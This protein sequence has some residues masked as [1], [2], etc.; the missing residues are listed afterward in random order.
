MWRRVHTLIKASSGGTCLNTTSLR[1]RSSPMVRMETLIG[2]AETRTIGRDSQ[3]SLETSNSVHSRH[4]Y[5]RPSSPASFLPRPHATPRPAKLAQATNGKQCPHAYHAH[6]S[7][8]LILGS[9]ATPVHAIGAAHS[10]WVGKSEISVLSNRPLCL[11]DRQSHGDTYYN[12]SG[13]RRTC[14]LSP[15]PEGHGRMRGHAQWPRP[16]NPQTKT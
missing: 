2:I 8:A 6:L 3:D 9:L 1:D 4:H 15:W 13:L 11:E 16:H 5:Y 14:S 10:D 7:H 12:R